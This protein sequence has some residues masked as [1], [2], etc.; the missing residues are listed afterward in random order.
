[1]FYW[2]VLD[3][4]IPHPVTGEPV[5]FNQVNVHHNTYYKESPMFENSD[6]PDEMYPTH[7]QYGDGAEV[8]VDVLRNVRDANWNNAVGFDWKE[9][10]VLVLDNVLAMHSRLSFTGTKRKLMAHLTSN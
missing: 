7:S 10:D 5:W 9:G 8:D 1:L 4:I 3:P 6:L 2:Y